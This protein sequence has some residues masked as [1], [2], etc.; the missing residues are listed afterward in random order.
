MTETKYGKYI[1]STKPKPGEKQ[2]GLQ[3]IVARAKGKRFRR[4]FFVPLGDIFDVDTMQRTTTKGTQQYL[5]STP[6]EMFDSG[7]RLMI[8]GIDQLRAIAP[9]E[10]I[11]IPGNHD[12]LASYH[13]AKT[14]EAHFRGVKNV[15][16]D[17]S[18]GDRKW[19]TFGVNLIAWMHG[20]IPKRNH[21]SWLQAQARTEWGLTKYAEIHAGHTHTQTVEEKSGQ[22][23]RFLP[24]TTD[25]SEWEN[26]DGYVGN[27][28]STVSFV[29]DSAKGLQEQWFTNV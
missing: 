19:K 11:F 20:D 3:D 7:A 28:R 13:L 8:W 9:V 18:H 5:T 23:L 2:E 1:V 22:V 21:F 25:A 6:Y 17:A 10:Y 24:S 14:I 4:I 12:R 26:G 16:V 29:W 27:V 15:T